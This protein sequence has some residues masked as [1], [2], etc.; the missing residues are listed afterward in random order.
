M[1]WKEFL[2]NA[3]KSW[4]AAPEGF[5]SPWP[6]WECCAGVKSGRMFNS[7]L[8]ASFNCSLWTVSADVQVIS[9]EKSS[10]VFRGLML[11]FLRP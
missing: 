5:P 3:V 10:L 4:R 8:A 9:V 7:G 2:N 11:F 6:S 1:V